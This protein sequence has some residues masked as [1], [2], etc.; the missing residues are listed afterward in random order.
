[1]KIVATIEARMTSSRLPGKVLMPALGKPMLGRLIERLRS[2]PLLSEIVLA[3]TTNPTDDVLEKFAHDEGIAVFRGSENDVMTRVIG[4]AESVGADVVVEITG[5]CPIIDPDIVSQTIQMFLSNPKADYVSNAHLR[6]YPDGMDVQVFSLNTL[7]NSAT[8]TSDP[9]DHEH[10]TLHIRNHP[11]LFPA[12]H[13]VAPPSLFWPELGL[14]LD[15][16]ADYVLLEKIIN[17]LEPQNP[18]FGCREVIQ[19]LINNPQWVAI[20]N[21]VTRK[22][23]S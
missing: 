20:N 9:L 22:G 3:T 18:L 15:E 23:D 19:L 7:K 12:V 4:A 2:V 5:D 14:T 21:G 10:V 13:L 16:Q 11:E 6:S 1:M 8:L 17:K